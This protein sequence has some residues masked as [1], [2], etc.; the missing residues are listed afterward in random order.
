MI[1]KFTLLAL[2]SLILAQVQAQDIKVT[3]IS[4]IAV[5]ATLAKGTPANQIFDMPDLITPAGLKFETKGKKKL[6]RTQ[7]PRSIDTILD[8]TEFLFSQYLKYN[9]IDQELPGDITMDATSKNKLP[10]LPNTKP[11]LILGDKADGKGGLDEAIEVDFNWSFS[12]IDGKWF[13]PTLYIKAELYENASAPVWKKEITIPSEEIDY[14]VMKEFYNI[15]IDPAKG[16]SRD[17]IKKTG[18][19]G[20]MLVDAYH[21]GLE[22][23]LNTPEGSQN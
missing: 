4:K 10:G 22:K 23:L 13:K 18:I 1:R 21:K 12:V 8:L 20:N 6:F 15:T 7:P 14:K 11:S 2:F 19:P 5:Y 3:G 9:L 17:L 16:F